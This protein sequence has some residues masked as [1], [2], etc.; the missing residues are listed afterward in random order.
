M[1]LTGYEQVHRKQDNYWRVWFFCSKC[2]KRFSDFYPKKGNIPSS[3]SC[4]VCDT[5]SKQISKE[6]IT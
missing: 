1:M 4:F 3:R 2:Q 6:K 5:Q